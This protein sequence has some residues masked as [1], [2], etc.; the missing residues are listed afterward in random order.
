MNLV[1]N[2]TGQE[3]QVGSYGDA[4]GTGWPVNEGFPSYFMSVGV[5]YN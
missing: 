1:V 3:G 5:S 4:E 2:P